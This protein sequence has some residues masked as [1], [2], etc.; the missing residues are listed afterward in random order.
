MTE[1]LAPAGNWD[2]ARA[3]VAN[4]ADAI[5][6]G[7]PRFNARMR[8]DNFTEADLPELM[9]FLHRHGVKGF[10]AFN[11]LIFPGELEGAVEQIELMARA[12]V[13]A[14]IVQD[15]GVAKLV[16]EIAPEMELHASTQMT[17]T[18]PEGMDFVDG[19]LKLDRAVL[20]REMS[21]EEIGRVNRKSEVPLEVFVHGA[22]CVA[23]SGQCLTSES[24]GQRSANRG[25]CAQAC[26]MPYELVVDGETKPMGEVRYLLSPQ[27]LAAVDV[28]PD[29]VK[30]GVVSF[31]I[32]GRLKSPDYVAAITRVYRKALDEVE[33]TDHD[34]YTLEMMFSRG[35][36]TGWLGGTNHP[37][38][39][40]GKWGKKRGVYVGEIAEVGD[41]WVELATMSVRANKGD[42]FV[43][44]AGEDRNDEQGGQVWEVEGNRLQFDHRAKVDW[45]RV[46]VG[47]G[48]WKTSDP[49]LEKEVR[50]T[51][52]GGRLEEK[53]EE[54]SITVSGMAD[55]P[56][57]LEC[58]GRKIESAKNLEK[59]ENRPLTTEVLVAQLGRLGGTEFE[60][61]EV[62][63][64]LAGEVMM[65]LSELNR[66]RRRL[67][68]SLKEEP[69]VKNG[70]EALARMMPE[71]SEKEF[72]TPELRVMCRSLKQVEGCANAG[73]KFIYCDFEDLRQYKEAV[74]IAREAEMTIFLATPRIQKPT[75]TGFFKLVEKAEPDGVLVRNLGGVQYFK[76]RGIRRVADFSL[77]VANPI[78]ARLLMEEGGFENLTMSYDLNESQVGDLLEKAPPEWFELTMHQH[79]PMFHMEHCVF[80][81]F[82]SEGTSVKDCGK[83]CEKHDV[84]LRDRVGQLHVLKADVGCRNTLFNGRA[85]TGAGSVDEFLSRGLGLFRIELLEEGVSETARLVRLYENFL[86]GEVT[87]SDLVRRLG[88]IERLGVTKGTLEQ[89]REEVHR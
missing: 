52:K 41:G 64:E 15:L 42:G 74:A 50:K 60:L 46:H 6:F 75:E 2:C 13:D 34:R 45:S 56:L 33:V 26:R 62:V 20:A 85:Q 54:L 87:S 10:V 31:K 28:I 4:G 78:T 51:W 69:E 86:D 71:V 21:V 40:H 44:D 80:C 84:Q 24:L 9:E 3:A 25:E 82:M 89:R 36:S 5:F 65:P 37:K 77:N 67:V 76:D 73:A 79:M 59:A 14:V 12:G 53:G 23:Y 18:S 29:L 35:L 43:F 57:V 55:Q 19:F 32:E 49:G 17:I 68:E 88:A 16:Q 58:R 47:Q 48:L 11:T 63:N 7:L 1:L 39:T 8:A 81:T 66:A 38:L 22:L 72:P 27:D 61:G 30:A 83:P 70:G